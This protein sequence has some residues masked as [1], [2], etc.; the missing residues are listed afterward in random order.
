MARNT[1]DQFIRG[2]QTT[3]HWIRM[4]VQAFRSAVVFAALVFA[5]VYG[6][7]CV[8]YYK[9]DILHVTWAH[10]LASFFVES[11]GEADRVLRYQHPAL[12]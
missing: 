5:V 3:Q 6:G 2:G 9:V 12:V 1:P 11:L 4:A 8:T 10:W 7:L